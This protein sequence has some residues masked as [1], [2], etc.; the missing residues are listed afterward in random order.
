[1]KHFQAANSDRIDSLVHRLL[2][3]RVVV[4]FVCS[5]ANAQLVGLNILEWRIALHWMLKL[6]GWKIKIPCRRTLANTIKPTGVWLQRILILCERTYSQCRFV[7]LPVPYSDPVEWFEQIVRDFFALGKMHILISLYPPENVEEVA[8]DWRQTRDKKRVELRLLHQICSQIK[9][10]DKPGNT[11][12]LGQ[13]IG[14]AIAVSEQN[15]KFKA[16]V[17]NP[18]VRAT[19][20]MITA[21]D[22]PGYRTAW[23]DQGSFQ[24]QKAG[25]RK[26]KGRS[27]PEQMEMDIEFWPAIDFGDEGTIEILCREEKLLWQKNEQKKVRIILTF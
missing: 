2:S 16:E 15:Q 18:F 13:L 3:D 7:G 26:S 4:P 22:E 11:L 5:E 12:P 19:R 14:V 8:E 23:V 24:L 17:F 20:A 1:M 6:E 25:H 10:L 21:M 27:P 9:A